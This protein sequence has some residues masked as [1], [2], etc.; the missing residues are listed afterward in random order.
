M[1]SKDIWHIILGN[2][3][4]MKIL[5]LT[6]IKYFS[7]IINL[8]P[9]WITLFRKY[10]PEHINMILKYDIKDNTISQHYIPLSDI[11]YFFKDLWINGAYFDKCIFLSTD[12]PPLLLFR[13]SG[14]CK[15]KNKRICKI[16]DKRVKG[17]SSIYVFT[18]SYKTE[19]KRTY[20][21]FLNTSDVSDVLENNP[22]ILYPSL[23]KTILNICNSVFIFSKYSTEKSVDIRN[24]PKFSIVV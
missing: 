23:H 21:N 22:E 11:K 16:C 10:F 18:V 4:I 13:M 9:L 2:L 20:E 19:Y 12:I 1:F 14:P 6:E 7:E 3:S 5:K 24:I 15:G 8:Q 17:T